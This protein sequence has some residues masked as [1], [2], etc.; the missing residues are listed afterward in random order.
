MTKMEGKQTL[1]SR[2]PFLLRP[3]ILF[4]DGLRFA[5][6]ECL[7]LPQSSPTNVEHR[8]ASSHDNWK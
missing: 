4:T 2:E 6:Q 5:V 8:P 7:K 3:K 1:L